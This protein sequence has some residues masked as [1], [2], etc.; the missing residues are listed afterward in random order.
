MGVN[1]ESHEVPPA[2]AGPGNTPENLISAF[3]REAQ[4]LIRYRRFA[5]TAR[6][7][8]MSATAALFERLADDQSIV[9]EGHLDFLRDFADPLTR[10]PLGSTQDNM[11]AALASEIDDGSELYP[12]FARTAAAEGFAA[13]ASWFLTLARAKSDNANRIQSLVQDNGAGLAES[14]DRR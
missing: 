4:V 1:N 13:L 6:Y 8:G 10:L 11:Q 3:A 7:E 14:S 2:A 5:K 9:V 12:A